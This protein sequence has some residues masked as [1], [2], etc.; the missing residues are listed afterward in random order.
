MSFTFT[1]VKAWKSILC[2][3]IL[4]SKYKKSYCKSLELQNVFKLYPYEYKSR[5]WD[6]QMCNTK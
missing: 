3:F 1:K 4:N 2:A 6:I 5:T